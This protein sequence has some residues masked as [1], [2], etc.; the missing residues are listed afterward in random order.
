MCKGHFGDNMV[1]STQCNAIT[2]RNSTARIMQMC[3]TTLK[4]GL[5]NIHETL[6]LYDK[7]EAKCYMQH[8]FTHNFCLHTILLSTQCNAITLGNNTPRIIIDKLKPLL[9]FEAKCYRTVY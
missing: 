7:C 4:N 3:I 5:P 8:S 1:A 2:L 9:L 6:L